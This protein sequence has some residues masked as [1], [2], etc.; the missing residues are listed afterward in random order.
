MK[1]LTTTLV[2]VL[3]CLFGFAEMVSAEDDK[4]EGCACKA[5]PT[6]CSRARDA[7]YAALAKE[8]EKAAALEGQIKALQAE[9]PLQC[10][11][12]NAQCDLEDL[13]RRRQQ[14][15]DLQGQL[16]ACKEAK[17]KLEGELEE[18]KK[19]QEAPPNESP[20]YG[21]LLVQLRMLGYATSAT[22]QCRDSPWGPPLEGDAKIG[23]AF[24]VTDHITLIPAAHVGL[25]QPPG[26]EAK[27]E[28][29]Y[30][31]SGAARFAASVF[32]LEVETSVMVATYSAKTTPWWSVGGTVGV[33]RKDR[34][35]YAG[36][37]LLLGSQGPDN[38]EFHLSWP[39]WMGPAVGG[40]FDWF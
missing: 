6:D 37:S 9:K 28:T 29:V 21:H 24:Y 35:F 7:C 1:R 17:G 27:Y 39:L 23:Y 33:Q 4:C 36:W 19:K 12:A 32:F 2:L 5:T 40:S 20:E 34:Q 25:I 8:R 11:P 38:G 15:D 31:V 3:W 13:G 26:G 10:P 16:A 14:V 18:L 30:G 22:G